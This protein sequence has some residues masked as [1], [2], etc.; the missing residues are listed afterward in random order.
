MTEHLP[1]GTGVCVCTLEREGPLTL[2]P[3]LIASPHGVIA[4]WRG[5]SYG[6]GRRI[7]HFYKLRRRAEFGKKGRGVLPITWN[8][9][10]SE[11]LTLLSLTPRT[12]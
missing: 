2:L 7:K 9:M 11:H 3:S 4:R 10:P 1:P 6:P 8:I 12:L 5:G